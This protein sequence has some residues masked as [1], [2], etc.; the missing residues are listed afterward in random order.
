[1]CLIRGAAITPLR[2]ARHGFAR[3]SFCARNCLTG[4][5]MLGSL[6]SSFK[7]KR[8]LIVSL[9]KRWLISKADFINAIGQPDWSTLAG[10]VLEA[11]GAAILRE[12]IV[13]QKPILVF[14]SAPL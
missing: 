4:N 14:G 6:E 2:G 10:R 8:L 11:L 12:Q 9:I 7:T 1:M 13:L 5:V 3:D